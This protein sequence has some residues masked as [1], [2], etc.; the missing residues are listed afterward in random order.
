MKYN[1]QHNIESR[2]CTGCSACMNICPLDA[3]IMAPGEEGFI[4]PE[5][6]ESVC[7]SCGKCMAVCPA[8]NI[9]A[10]NNLKPSCYA[11]RA[12]DNI[13]KHSSSGGVFSVLARYALENGFFVGG[14]VFDEDFDLKIALSN[15]IEGVTAMRG[16]KYIQANVNLVFREIRCALDAGAKVL[17]TGTPC[18]IAGLK[19]YLGGACDG[20]FTVDVLCHGA[21][22]QKIF[23]QHLAE[24]ADGEKILAITFR[25]K[26]Y[27]WRP[28]ATTLRV[29]FASGR[30]YEGKSDSDYYQKG[31]LSNMILR[32][33]CMDCPFCAF[34][35]QGDLSMGD[36][37]W[38]HTQPGGD[39]EDKGT[40]L[41]LVNSDKG[42]EL[43]TILEKHAIFFKKINV[44][45]E[46]LPNRVSAKIAG[47]G[48]RER[49]FDLVAKRKFSEAAS[50]C[51][52]DYFDVALV[53]P[54]GNKNV[55]G[56]LTYFALYNVIRD[57]GYSVKLV[58]SPMSAPWS[59]KPN[60]T[61]FLDAPVYP[62]Y[63]M[64]DPFPSK[65]AMRALNDKC[66]QFVVG[67]DQVFNPPLFKGWGKYTQLD[68]VRDDKKKIAYASS[69]GFDSLDCGE[70]ERAEMAY[71]LGKF[72]AFSVRETG[73][74][75]LCRD[76]L[77]VEAEAVL[78]PVFLCDLARYEELA[79]QAPI[80][81]SAGER[82]LNAY[83]LYATPDK[84]KLT[85]GAARDKGIPYRLYS[86][87]GWS[88]N[89]QLEA[90]EDT[91]NARVRDM[92]D[93]EFFVTDSFHGICLAIL[94]KKNF[95]TLPNFNW[96]FSRYQSILEN[97]GLMCR[98]VRSFDEYEQR[99]SELLQP[100]DWEEVYAK[101]NPLIEKSRAWLKSHLESVKSAPLSDYDIFISILNDYKNENNKKLDQLKKELQATINDTLKEKSKNEITKPN[102]YVLPDNEYAK[103]SNFNE[104]IN[105]LIERK[106]A[107]CVLIAARDTPAGALNNDL[108][109]LLG[110]LGLKTN[111]NE[112]FRH[113]YIALIDGNALFF[114]KVG[115]D[116]EVLN[117][118]HK[119]YN[120]DISIVSAPYDN[121]CRAEIKINGVD[122]S[123]NGRGLN[124]AL[125]DRSTGRVVD[126]VNFDAWTPE[127]KATRKTR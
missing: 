121:G 21:P 12:A 54:Y 23:R 117:S 104:Y 37:W 34:P 74:V 127:I 83:I 110:Q 118:F 41:L 33:S 55:G 4:F 11:F 49:F 22:S 25:D 35:R 59:G 113:A 82:F 102:K 92:R 61:D 126:S 39:R 17:F 107:L 38:F 48:K 84:Q 101:L 116:G 43:L 122:W 99:R 76:Q 90:L 45:P 3:I 125:L 105:V 96:A 89:F 79:R 32:K 109:K 111:L 5:V 70:E 50:Q 64:A 81:N 98:M 51:H 119:L 103:I 108:L 46:K 87:P 2:I 29:E 6:D 8:A 15:T 53:G 24:I 65:N 114:E 72:D 94:F 86:G 26:R 112:H 62:A 52:N 44:D 97:T 69:F 9:P 57:M 18:Q 47:N 58:G 68:W 42:E 124:F 14:A 30:V 80:Q 56:F 31:F 100:V 85:A 36:F 10:A 77:E 123:V 120:I 16:S 67:S 115:K 95:I 19:N 91:L 93:C 75:A 28:D 7:V 1:V 13:R 106:S 60:F 66:G 88:K 40:S 20:L 71:F 78:D 73:G 27:G 63:A